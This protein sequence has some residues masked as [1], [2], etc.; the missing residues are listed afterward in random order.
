M[1]FTQRQKKAVCLV[2]AVA[3]IA[4]VVASIILSLI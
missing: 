1:R 4:T 2:V 3:M